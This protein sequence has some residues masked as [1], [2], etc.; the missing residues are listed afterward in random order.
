VQAETVEQET[1]GSSGGRYGADG[2]KRQDFEWSVE[3]T[4]L[5]RVLAAWPCMLGKRARPGAFMDGALADTWRGSFLEQELIKLLIHRLTSLIPISLERAPTC[6]RV[7]PL[8][9]VRIVRY[10]LFV[11]HHRGIGPPSTSRRPGL[12]P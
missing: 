7:M 11:G 8:F 1:I 12:R 2:R 4:D 9:A 6:V 10:P 3:A 5:E